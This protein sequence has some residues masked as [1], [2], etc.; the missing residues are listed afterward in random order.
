MSSLS[1]DHIERYGRQVLL[2]EIGGAG[3]A[4]LLG[5]RVLIVGAGGLGSPAAL[6]LAA[7]GVGRITLV[8]PDAVALSNLHR[9]ILYGDEDVGAPKVAAAASGLRARSPHLSVEGRAE[10]LDV[11]NA[12]ARFAGHDVVL[13]GTDDFETRFL[14]NDT[15]VRM[16]VPLVH[17]AVLR[18]SGQVTVVGPGD[19]GCFRCLFEAPPPPGEVPPCSE[20]GVVGAVAGV[21]GSV[22]AVEALKVLLGIGP[23]DLLA[24]RLWTFDGRRGTSRTVPLPKNPGCPACGGAAEVTAEARP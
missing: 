12:E 17:G 11:T 20:A 4:R 19:G 16:G 18:W 24:G 13:D 1:D 22:M 21:V 14:C 9:Q 5:A 3:Q 2:D 8:D 10:R 23:D 15:A 7:A 6:Y